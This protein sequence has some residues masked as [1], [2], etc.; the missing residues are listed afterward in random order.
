MFV[1]EGQNNSYIR[2]SYIIYVKYGFEPTLYYLEGPTSICDS[3]F[4][5]RNLQAYIV[6]P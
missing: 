6:Q 1:N 3:E 4:R 5:I 2:G